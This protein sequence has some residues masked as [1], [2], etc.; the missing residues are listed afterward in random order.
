[1]AIEDAAK[2]AKINKVNILVPKE[3]LKKG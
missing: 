2:S 3:E 1:V